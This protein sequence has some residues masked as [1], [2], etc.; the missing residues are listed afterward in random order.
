[1]LVR[2]LHDLPDLRREGQERPELLPGVAQQPHDCRVPV[3]PRVLELGDPLPG[4]RDRRGGVDLTQV[5]ADLPPIVLLVRITRSSGALA[6]S[7]LLHTGR[8]GT[9]AV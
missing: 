8:C 2:G 3:T 9:Y 6:I 7:T 5:L 1:M 4:S